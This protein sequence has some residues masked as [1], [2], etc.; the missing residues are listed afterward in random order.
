[1][2]RKSSRASIPAEISFERPVQ[3]PGIRTMPAIAIFP[4][5]GRLAASAILLCQTIRAVH[6]VV[7]VRDAQFRQQQAEIAA[8]LQLGIL[9]DGCHIQRQGRMPKHMHQSM[10][11]VHK[12]L[13]TRT[14]HG[15]DTD[16]TRT[17]HGRNTDFTRTT[18]PLKR[19]IG[20]SRKSA[21]NPIRQ[22]SKPYK[23]F[24]EFS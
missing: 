2:A 19:L 17:E 13:E 10:L 3:T 20:Q 16:G 15:R 22:S 18:D 12:H 4:G 5:A 6:S 21:C 24:R 7:F 23:N 8:V 14:K 11:P 9:W 1:M